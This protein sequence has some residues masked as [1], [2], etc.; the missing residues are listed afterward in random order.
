MTQATEQQAALAA[1][2]DR[3]ARALA[4]P[5]RARKRRALILAELEKYDELVA[6]L[7]GALAEAIRGRD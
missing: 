1:D 5:W 3:I 7:G 6:W 2:R 4:R